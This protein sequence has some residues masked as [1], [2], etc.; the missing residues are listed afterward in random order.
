MWPATVA[1]DT[2][3]F[4]SGAKLLNL[5]QS[6]HASGYATAVLAGSFEEAGLRGRFIVRPGDL[7]LHGAIDCHAHCALARRAL[8]YSS[9]RSDGSTGLVPFENH[10]G[11]LGYLVHRS[12]TSLLSH[13]SEGIMCSDPVADGS[14]REETR[15]PRRMDNGRVL[16]L[17]ARARE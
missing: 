13:D 10:L 17:C 15:H 6:Y 1:L 11:L 2:G 5:A 16:G 12:R 3:R 7:L 8:Y 14:P 9:F 4:N